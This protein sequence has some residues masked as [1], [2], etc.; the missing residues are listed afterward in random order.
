VK[1]Q[2]VAMDDGVVTGITQFTTVTIR[3]KNNFYC[4]YMH[5]DH[6]S[7]DAAGLKVGQNIT[8]GTLPPTKPESD[9]GGIGWLGAL[10]SAQTAMFLS[11][12]SH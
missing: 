2:A 1:W 3:S 10:G 9:C 12:R 11:S 5:M 6:G 7:I 4:R 8:K